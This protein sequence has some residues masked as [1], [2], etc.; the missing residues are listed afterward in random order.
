MATDLKVPL[1]D[2]ELLNLALGKIPQ[3]MKDAQTSTE[4]QAKMAELAAQATEAQQKALA[5][6]GIAA[7]GTILALDK[8]VT[9]MQASGLISISADQAAINYQKSLEAVD[10][11]IAKN[12]KNLDITTKGGKENMEAWL[13]QASAANAATLANAKNG[14]SSADLQVGLTAQYT[15]LRDNAIAFGKGADEADAMARK[16]LGIPKDVKIET[17]IQNYADTMAKAQAIKQAVDGINSHK[18][19]FFTTDAT[20]FYDPTGG[21]NGKGAGTGGKSNGSPVAYADGG[22]IYGKGPKGVDSVRAV[23]APGEHVLT[24]DEVDRM[25]GQAGVYAMRAAIKSGAAYSSNGS[26]PTATVTQPVTFSPQITVTGGADTGAVVQEVWG[27]FKFEAQKAGLR[28][29]G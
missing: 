20:G 29:G 25:G 24:A 4:G 27:K 10:A 18:T 26:T 17:A 2:Q 7:D 22:A 28:I 5:D 11:A 12:G 19:I 3:K 15:Q 14:E 6:L 23:L 21:T 16:A 13:G 8:L 9:A 1:T